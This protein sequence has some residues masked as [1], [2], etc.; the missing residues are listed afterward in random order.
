MSVE[1]VLTHVIENVSGL[2][3]QERVF[4]PTVDH[5]NVPWQ[6]GYFKNNGLLAVHVYCLTHKE[7]GEWRINGG[8]KFKIIKPTGEE[9]TSDGIEFNFGSHTHY[10]GSGYLQLISWDHLERILWNDRL[11]IEA[12]VTIN[13][14][15]GIEAKKLRNFDESN[16]NL[17]D[18]ALVVE[19]QKFFVSKLILASQS[20]YFNSLFF[21]NFKESNLSEMT[22][23]D[24]DAGDFQ[25]FLEVLY[26]EPAL[27][28][29][30]VQGVL[31]LT[32]MY[33]VKN[34]TR[35]CEEF[36]IRESADS[37]RNKLKIAIKFRLKKLKVPILKIDLYSFSFFF[38]KHCIDS[39]KSGADVRAVLGG[40][41]IEEEE[42]DFLDKSTYKALLEKSIFFK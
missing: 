6:M 21:G 17:S 13:E 30:N 33:D 5:F 11:I 40:S 28:N 31:A 38:Q 14:I 8:I 19:E 20:P 26:H 41:C 25:H 4:S 36:L 18:V 32:D 23:N 3:E 42:E 39:V 9:M 34:A 16:K 2:K 37:L 15:T 24:I 29:S 7:L 10:T 27:T 22:L 1:F 12:H 35:V